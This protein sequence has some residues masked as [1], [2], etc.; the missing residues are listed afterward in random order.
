MLPAI[1]RLPL[2]T[3]RV[4]VESIAKPFH[5]SFFTILRAKQDSRADQPSRFAVIVS[6]KI[7]KHAVKRN[8]LRRQISSAITE[9][10]P[11]LNPGF[12]TIILIKRTLLEATYLQIKDE[13]KA[14]LSQAG[15]L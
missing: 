9:F 11:E 5:S 15:I 13:L 6:K 12:D 3:S 14:I 10:I 8:L 7:S 2:R 4:Q 1:H